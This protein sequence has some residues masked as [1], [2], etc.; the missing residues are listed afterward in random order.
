VP[1]KLLIVKFF[2]YKAMKKN[3]GTTD[4]VIRLIIGVLIAALG[5]IYKSWW[6]LLALLPIATALVNFCG[7]YYILGI[8]TCPLKKEE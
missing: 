5:I 2:K 7:L 6:G 3:I 1:L 8:N 4:K